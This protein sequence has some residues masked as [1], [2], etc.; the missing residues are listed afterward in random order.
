MIGRL[1]LSVVRMAGY[2]CL[3]VF[4]W[5]GSRLASVVMLGVLAVGLEA[6]IWLSAG[7]AGRHHRH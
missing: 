1:L 5:E 7:G 2:G 6:V 3:L 4:S